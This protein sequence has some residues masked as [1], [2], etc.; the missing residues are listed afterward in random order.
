MTIDQINSKELSEIKETL[1][2]QINGASLI[3][4]SQDKSIQKALDILW[5]VYKNKEKSD[6]HIKL[7]IKNFIK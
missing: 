3:D 6:C 1:F 2:S 4:L 7:L 5:I